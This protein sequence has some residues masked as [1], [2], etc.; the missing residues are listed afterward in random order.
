MRK[1]R[2][3]EGREEG[4]RIDAATNSRRHGRPVHGAMSRALPPDCLGSATRVITIERGSNAIEE[5][6][7]KGASPRRHPAGRVCCLT[8]AVVA[9]VAAP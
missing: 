1:K 7:R 4:G 8:P 9:C 5:R 6:R 2:I 3:R